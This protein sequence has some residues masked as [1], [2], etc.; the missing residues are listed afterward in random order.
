MKRAELLGVHPHPLRYTAAVWGAEN[1]VPMSKI[2]QYLR[3]Q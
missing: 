2:S 1:E 3:T